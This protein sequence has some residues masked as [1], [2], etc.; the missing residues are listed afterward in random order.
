[1]PA[2]CA[3][4]IP[5]STRPMPDVLLAGATG[6][7]G[8]AIAH[9]LARRR[10]PARLLTRS[11]AR[12]AELDRGRC[13]IVRA[14]VTRPE[15]LRG[16]M[17]GVDTVIS[18]VGITRQRD[19]LT[20]REVDYQAN[21]NLLD[22]ARRSGVRRF[23]Y[24]SVLHG[25]RLRRLAICDAKERFVD[26]LRASGLDDGVIRPNGFFTDLTAFVDMARRGRVVLFG[27]GQV[28]ANPI[29][30]DDLATVCVDAAAGTA[31]EVEVGGP[32]VLTQIEI[33]RLAFEA[34]GRPPRI[35]HV[36]DVARRGV[37]ALARTFTS[38]RIHGPLEFF[39]TVT[40]RDMVA[41]RAGHR[42]LGAF[43][44]AFARQGAV[45]A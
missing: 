21:L 36:P 32:E 2:P 30:P 20:Y 22:E 43:F 1:M 5:S 16:V 3:T 9:E 11:L 42:P 18:T 40:A 6:T 25:D 34:V 19:G 29:H 27:D 26:A 23:V 10:H 4:R 37:L 35:T 13:E 7:L 17:E 24:V 39:L 41:P 38:S 28:R 12:A 45:A 31:R 44:Q 33:A 14:E 15:T 8:R